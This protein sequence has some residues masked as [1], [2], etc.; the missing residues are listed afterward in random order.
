MTRATM[1]DKLMELV[2]YACRLNPSEVIWINDGDPD[3]DW[4]EV[5]NSNTIVAC[6]EWM[7]DEVSRRAAI[8]HEPGLDAPTAEL[9]GWR[10]MTS[11]IVLSFV[12]RNTRA[13]EVADR[14]LLAVGGRLMRTEENIRGVRIGSANM[15]EN[16]T[17]AL[18]NGE[19]ESRAAVDLVVRW[20]LTA[21]VEEVDTGTPVVVV[22]PQH[23]TD[24]VL[25]LTVPEGPLDNRE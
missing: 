4:E 9:Y 15:C 6:L 23:P 19:H 24:E 14:M 22:H 21:A 8:Q 16:K 18:G 5:G 2:L 12:R 13:A 10:Q 7:K 25:E 3:I 17:V 20:T 11:D 1:Q